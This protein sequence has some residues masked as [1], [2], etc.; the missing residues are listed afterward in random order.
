[1]VAYP[2]S[3]VLV[4][5][6]GIGMILH[7]LHVSQFDLGEDSIILGPANA[8]L[9]GT[10]LEWAHTQV[11]LQMCSTIEEKLKAC[12]DPGEAD[13]E[14][15][16]EAEEAEE[17]EEAEDAEETEKTEEP[18]PPPTSKGKKPPLKRQKKLPDRYMSH[19]SQSDKLLTSSAAL[20]PGGLL[21]TSEWAMC[22]W[23]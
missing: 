8:H 12:M 16:Q 2:Q 19:P 1:M 18:T 4:V 17:E 9:H 23:L 14:A 3:R 10:K 20:L 7:D 5:C 13:Q 15:D 11:L 22:P 6:L 21:G